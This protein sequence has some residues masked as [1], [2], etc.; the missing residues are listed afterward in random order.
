MRSRLVATIEGYITVR[1]INRRESKVVID[2]EDENGV[3]RHTL[4][5]D[6][7][8]RITMTSEFGLKDMDA[9]RPQ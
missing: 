3:H 8:W 6:K 1:E 7:P 4:F 2:M 5:I 9:K